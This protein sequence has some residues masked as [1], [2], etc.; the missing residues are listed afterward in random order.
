MQSQLT[1]I[2]IKI[3]KEDMTMKVI[4]LRL[5]IQ[6]KINKPDLYGFILYQL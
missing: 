3:I 4:Y 6:I 1:Q 2:I 5:I